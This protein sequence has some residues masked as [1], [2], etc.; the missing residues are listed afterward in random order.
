MKYA[1][2][3]LVTDADGTL[4]TDDKR[5]LDVDKSAIDEFISEGGLFT[6]ATGRGIGLAR[7]VV[8]KI[9]TERLNA[10][11]VIFNGAVV[12]DFANNKKL[13]ETLLCSKGV[14]Y[15]KTLCKHFPDV[16]TE[17]LIGDDIYVTNTNAYEEAHL[18]FGDVNPIRCDFA[19]LPEIGWFKAVFVDTPEKIQKML[20]FAKMNP[21]D[22]IHYVSSAPMFFEVLPKGVNKGSGL[23]K[24][25][26]IMG[27]E[28]K[29]II[30]VGDYMNDIEMLQI[31]DL[32]VAVDNAEEVV[33]KVADIVVCDNNSGSIRAIVD[34][35]KQE[36]I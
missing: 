4:F 30:A 23:S 18:E 10:P 2:T 3:L 27:L 15:I 22:E 20:D 33:K 9:G 31:A 12:Y 28:N 19:K 34:Y 6:I 13:S 26:Q 32:A 35:L 11:A 24:M 29:R 36:Q 1:G 17:I 25:I 8:D 16:G 14:E 5:I 7:D 21:C